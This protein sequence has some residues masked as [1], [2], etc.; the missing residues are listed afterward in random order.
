M[1]LFTQNL[2]FSWAQV[3][4]EALNLRALSTIKFERVKESHPGRERPLVGLVY[5][6][7][8]TFSEPSSVRRS[9]RLSPCYIRAHRLQRRVIQ[10]A[11]LSNQLLVYIH[12]QTQQSAARQNRQTYLK[13][14]VSYQLI[15]M[16][17]LPFSDGLTK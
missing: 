9:R 11:I 2:T 13:S 12:Q 5:F 1:A 15:I 6:F 14:I 10:F 4:S 3:S 17:K 16:H 8:S 7:S